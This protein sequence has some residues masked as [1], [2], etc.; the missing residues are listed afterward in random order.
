LS[1]S[2]SQLKGLIPWVQEFIY[3]GESYA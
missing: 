2:I 1:T 3:R